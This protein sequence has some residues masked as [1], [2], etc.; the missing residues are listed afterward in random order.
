MN[1]VQYINVQYNTQG[2]YDHLIYAIFLVDLSYD[3][4][5]L[6]YANT[7]NISR[8]LRITFVRIRFLVCINNLN[9]LITLVMG[10]QSMS[11]RQRVFLYV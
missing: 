10:L 2:I 8:V 6:W 9:I 7:L 4:C 5:D 3:F 1:N 11:N